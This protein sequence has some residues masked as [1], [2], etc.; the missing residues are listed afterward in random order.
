VACD[1]WYARRR[2]DAE[3]DFFRRAF[4]GGASHTRLPGNDCGSSQ[5]LYCLTPAARLLGSYGMGGEIKALRAALRRVASEYRGTPAA[6]RSPADAVLRDRDVDA[7][8]RRTP[9]QGG[10]ILSVHARRLEGVLG[11]GDLRCVAGRHGPGSEIGR[12]HLWLTKAEKQSL[13]PVGPRRGTRMA[14]PAAV[15]ERLLRFHLV[16]N[17]RGEPTMWCRDHI[18]FADLTLLV[19]ETAEE[20]VQVRIE[21]SALLASVADIEDAD[22]GY[23]ARLL[24]SYC[25][26]ARTQEFVR[27]DLVAYGNH[28]GEGQFTSGA[29]PGRTP[30]GIVFELTTGTAPLDLVPPQGA[31]YPREY[32]GTL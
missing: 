25:Y 16:D 6:Q 18:R 17:T 22:L 12:D 8:Y 29:R 15:A 31:R 2:D 32:F 27:F 3:G 11:T 28:W 5:G 7:R 26:N 30:L 13:M 1:D 14:M 19:E 4:H 20:T 10:L 21:G 24:G 23:Q 9:P